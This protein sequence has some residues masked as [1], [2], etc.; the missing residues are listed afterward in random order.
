MNVATKI[1]LY[2]GILFLLFLTSLKN[3]L[4]FHSLAELFSI[5]IAFGI[6]VIGWNSRKYYK[7]NYLLFIGIAYLF[8]AFFDTLHTL[9][10]KG[11][12]IFK[13]YDDNNLPPQLWLVA[14]YIESIALLLAPFFFS[15]PVRPWRIIAILS[16]VSALAIY[17]IFFAGIFPVCFVT[18]SGLTPFKIGSE[19]LIDIILIAALSLL[20]KNREHFDPGVLRLLTLS[21]A[22]TMVTELCFT[23]YV[24]L[25]GISNLVGHFFKIFSFWFMYRA[26]IETALSKPYDLLFRELRTNEEQFANAFN[27]APIGIALVAPDGRWLKVNYAVCAMVGYTEQE[28]LSKTFQNITHPDDLEVDLD[29]ARRV[30]NGEID[31]FQMEKRYIHKGGSFIWVLISVSLVRDDER[32]PL[33][34]IA[35]IIDITERKTIESVQSFIS[36]RGWH[37]TEEGFFPALARFLSETLSMEFICI[38]RLIGDGNMALTVAVYHNG[39]FEDNVEYALKDTPCGDVVGKTICCF[40][41]DV[42]NLFP[43]DP[44]LREIKAESYAGITLWGNNEEPIGLI[45]VIGGKPIA[46]QHL[47]ETVLQYVAPRAAGELEREKTEELLRESEAR[48]RSYYELGLVGMAI[49]SLEK[50][51]IQCNDCLCSM[52]GYTREE[53]TSKN[54]AELTHPD[55]LAADEAQFFR[56]LQ[57]EIDGYSM[58]KRFIRKDGQTLQASLSV[59]CVRNQHG[60]PEHFVVMIQDITARKQTEIKLREINDFL[61]LT[62]KSANLGLWDWDIP[63]G[64]LHWSSELFRI[65]GL[66]PDASEPSFDVWRSVVHPDDLQLAESLISDAIRDHSELK[67]EYRVIMPSGGVRWVYATGKA[68]YDNQG[69]AIRLTGVCMDITERKDAELAIYK[70]KNMLS[71]GQKIAHMGT[72]EYVADTETTVWS[73]EEYRIYGLNSEEPSPTYDVMLAKNIHP[74][75]AALL[76]QTFTAA[77]QSGSVY[78]FEH[79]IVRPDGIVRWVYDLANPYFDENGRLVRYVGTTLDITDRKKAEEALWTEKA[80]LRSLIDSASDLIYFKDVNSIYLGCN[81]ASEAFTGLSE[82]EQIGKSDF[83]LFDKGFAEHIVTSD[84]QVLESGVAVHLQELVIA[85]DGNRYILDT[86]KT[87]ILGKD[88]QPIGLVGISRD[89]TRQKKEELLAAARLHLIEYSLSHTLDELLTATLDQ[90]EELTNSQIGFFHLLQEDQRTLTLH[91]WSTRTARDFCRAEGAGSHYDIEKAGV[92]VDCIHQRQPIIHNDYASLPHRKGMP[93]GHATVI[94]ELAVP[95]FRSNKIVGILGIGNKDTEYTEEDV[96][97]ASRFADL[98]WDIAERR[99][100]QDSLTE[101]YELF[102]AAFNSAPIMITISSIEDGTY[103]DAN[104]LFLNNSG[105]SREEVIGKTSVELGWISE[106]DRMQLK[107]SIQQEGIIHGQEISLHTKVGQTKLCKYWGEVISVA[108]RKRLLSI[109]LDITEQHKAEQQLHQAQKMESIGSLAG[110]VA[111][112]FN[113]MLTVIIGHVQLGMM[114]LNTNH[115]VC[116]HLA[117]ILKTAE[118]SADLTRQLLAFA[119]KQA[120]LPK[121]ID[122]NDVV[123]G[124]LKMLRR[125]IG[126]DIQLAWLPASDLWQIKADPSQIDQILANLCVN[127]RDAIK[128]TGRITIETRNNTVDANYCEGNLEALPGDYVNLSVSDDGSGMD[129]ETMARVF[130]PFFTTKGLGEGTGLG[131]ATVYGIVKQ[132]NGFINIYSELGQGTTFTIHLP[133][134]E[135]QSQK[136]LTEAKTVALPNGQ[137]T[138]LLVEDEPGILHVT[139]LLL[140]RQGYTL[141]TAGTPGEAVRLALEHVGEINLLITDVIMPEMNGKELANKLLFLNPQLKC[142]YMSGYTA[143]VIAQNGVLNEGVYFIQK[144][145]SLPDLATKVRDVLDG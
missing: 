34:F 17:A 29:Q 32:R 7:N 1:I 144:P 48:F 94:R 45:A 77:L 110:G 80:F 122:L 60:T 126:E 131:L 133:R 120:I 57:G 118:R 20:H 128:G 84:K 71:E 132:N 16:A 36:E 111:H 11:M 61:A 47:V 8:V 125:L 76:H 5:V 123:D 42:A 98:A 124:M 90:I 104:Q 100:I 82:Q 89:I 55:D 74:D 13:G 141:L 37:S 44:V 142:L 91:A 58:D 50:G 119:R 121:I 134:Q 127:A 106:A 129:M 139:A 93:P 30:L 31:N 64:N 15:R 24:H 85:S 69:D 96:Q 79:R 116:D 19:Y 39:R 6:F 10:Y 53:L 62:Q 130:E 107:E 109:A 65:F 51:W 117:E 81:K 9:A 41:R 105:F 140:G 28:L 52:L 4:L 68:N 46:N 145:F 75:D 78:K 22:C 137:E 103:L 38:D 88:R 86:V 115:P 12:N 21:I 143:D 135:E 95:I 59:R 35:H 138:I 112:D 23:V 136:T 67:N 113:N 99:Q 87:P 72:F 2:G 26:I 70:M 63:T 18:G 108:G 27:Y 25:Y 54:W 73:E 56:V 101:S 66:D 97:I 102:T 114:K 83:E 43:N 14:R 92:W 33:H 40:P 3:Y 49:T